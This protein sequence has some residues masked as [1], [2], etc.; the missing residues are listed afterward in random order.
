MTLVGD[1][2]AQD[3]YPGQVN[4]VRIALADV[5]PPDAFKE[6]D[7]LVQH[8]EPAEGF[9]I[10]RGSFTTLGVHGPDWAFRDVQD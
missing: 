1:T 5:L 9:A 6:G 4:G 7:S 10:S 3:R 2:S 8:G